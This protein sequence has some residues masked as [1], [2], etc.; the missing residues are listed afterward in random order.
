M[1]A[2]IKRDNTRPPKLRLRMPMAAGGA[3]NATRQRELAQVER[4]THSTME[5]TLQSAS[6]ASAV[7]ETRCP[8]TYQRIRLELG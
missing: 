8:R 4:L 5:R 1:Y 6:E 7:L 2:A 3:A